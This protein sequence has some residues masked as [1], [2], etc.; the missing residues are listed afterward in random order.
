[1]SRKTI[2][3]ITLSFYISLIIGFILNEDSLGGALGDS[4][5][6]EKY[7]FQIHSALVNTY[8]KSIFTK[9]CE[10]IVNIHC[11]LLII[12]QYTSLWVC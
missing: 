9:E 12:L 4:K 5:A 8:A 6:L 11:E 2:N 3:F 7:F 1:M 10:K